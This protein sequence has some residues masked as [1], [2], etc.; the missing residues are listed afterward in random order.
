[1]PTRGERR[2]WLRNLLFLALVGGGM[3]VLAAH[4][5]PPR[6][7]SL[8]THYDRPRHWDGDGQATVER[9]DAAFRLSWSEQ[10]LHAATPAAELAIARRISLGL[11]G[12]IPSLEE[13]RQ[14]E[15]L[16][17]GER[18]AWWIDHVLD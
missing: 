6:Q 14:F 9:L 10:G 18:L 8:L 13:I 3:T 12:T 16:P 15:A 7:A 11:M 1:M 5:I 17:A 4:L 2:M